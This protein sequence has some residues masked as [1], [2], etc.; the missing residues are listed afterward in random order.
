LK[1]KITYSIAGASLSL[2]LISILSKGFGFVREIVYAGT[3]GLSKEFDLYLVSAAIPITINTA[4]LYI[5]QHYFVPTYHKIKNMSENEAVIFSSRSFYLFLLGGIILGVLLAIFSNLIIGLFISR[6]QTITFDLSRNLFLLFL[7]SLPLN[8]GIAILSA[9]LQSEYR[10][11]LPAVLQLIMNII[12]I[13]MVILFSDEFSVYILPISFIAGN[14]ITL[15]YMVLKLNSL[16]KISELVAIKKN[17][18]VQPDFLVS[19][20]IIELVSLSYPIVDRYFYELIPSGGIAA[21]NYAITVYSMPVSIFTIALI[22][23]IFPRFSQ[24]AVESKEDLILS[25]KKSIS[26]NIYLMVPISVVLIFFGTDLIRLFYERGKFSNAD[27]LMTNEV[28]KLYT[29]SL[30][31]YSTYLIAIKLLYSIDK[32]KLVL[33][34]SLAALLIKIVLNSIL[35][36]NYYQNGLAISTSAVFFLLCVSGFIA[37]GKQL[38]QKLNYFIFKKIIY[39]LANA[40]VSLLIITLILDLFNLSSTISF[41]TKLF[42]F[43]LIFIS[44]S[45]LLESDD[46]LMARTF[47]QNYFRNNFSN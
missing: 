25:L 28:L 27:T 17:N 12:I 11:I 47:I 30:I 9:Y 16:L 35:V 36:N 10:F 19:L 24:S 20:I 34:L 3:F 31:F 45:K 5:A 1:K 6:D 29:F 15:I 44:N 32:F 37:A 8:A 42:L 18:I 2:V 22:T 14:I 21:L 43:P 39:N 38:K 33:V 13:L 26:I 4:V 7:I 46:Y 40:L 23:T 41:L